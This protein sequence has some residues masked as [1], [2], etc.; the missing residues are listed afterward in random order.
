MINKIR[1]WQQNLTNPESTAYKTEMMSLHN[2]VQYSLKH[3][4]SMCFVGAS[5]QNKQQK[6]HITQQQQQQEQ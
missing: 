4:N 3:A 5:I 2:V 6:S 1:A